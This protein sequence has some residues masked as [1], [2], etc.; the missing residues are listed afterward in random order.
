MSTGVTYIVFCAQSSYDP[1]QI[2]GESH[3]LQ[4]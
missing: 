3:G 1:A 2:Q 4:F